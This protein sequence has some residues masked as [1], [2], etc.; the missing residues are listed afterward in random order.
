CREGVYQMLQILTRITKGEGKVEDIQTLR[1]LGK[2]VTEMSL[3]ALGSTAAN[4]MLST[5]EYFIEEYEEHIKSKKCRAGVCTE[6][7]DF[8]I[9]PEKC[10]GCQMCARNCPVDCISGEKKQVHVIDDSKCVRCGVCVDSCPVK[11]DAVRVIS[12]RGANPKIVENQ[13]R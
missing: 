7:I 4:P 12:P 13:V 5:L 2:G 8:W 1:E 6:L 3:C 11:V 9:D 10:T